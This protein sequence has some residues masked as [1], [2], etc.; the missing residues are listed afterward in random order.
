[1]WQAAQRAM[2]VAAAGRRLRLPQL[3]QVT[4]SAML[5]PPPGSLGS[6]TTICWLPVAFTRMVAPLPPPAPAPRLGRGPPRVKVVL[7]GLGAARLTPHNG[8]GCVRTCEPMRARRR[9][10][11]SR[12]V[13]DAD[14]GRHLGGETKSLRWR[15]P[16][17]PAP[18]T[19]R[20]A[21]RKAALQAIGAIG[22]SYYLDGDGGA[23][24]PG[25]G[26]VVRTHYFAPDGRQPPGETP[27]CIAVSPRLLIRPPW[28][29]AATGD[30][31][32]A[33]PAKLS[34]PWCGRARC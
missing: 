15:L 30:E 17:S 32:R 12:R 3:E 11:T 25:S 20:S 26:E 7:L 6:Y 9:R 27:G 5:R 14:P 19:D 13:L 10:R 24:L 2:P 29:G 21:P 34:S 1:V 33:C 22:W 28:P 16:P 18:V 4:I 23:S 31:N 8:R